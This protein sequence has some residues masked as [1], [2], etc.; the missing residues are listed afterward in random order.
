MSDWP[1]IL[2]GR[3]DK[4]VLRLSRKK[5]DRLLKGKR[6]TPVTVT[7]ER[8]HGHRSL[9]ANRYYFGVCLKLISEYSG[10]DVNEA[11]EAMKALFLPKALA[12]C[13]G[14]GIVVDEIVIGGST[15]QMNTNDFHDFIERVRRFA[16]EDLGLNIPDPDPDWW[17]KSCPEASTSNATS[18]G[19]ST[20]PTSIR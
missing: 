19:Q 11:H 4:G 12:F 20:P 2:P 13:N 8:Q 6:D 18:I 14:N 15:R 17:L 5:L 7:I 10:Y 9:Q 16:A 3:L 1:I